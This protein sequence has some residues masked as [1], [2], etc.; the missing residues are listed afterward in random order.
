MV[1]WEWNTKSGNVNVQKVINDS[2]LLANFHVELAEQIDPKYFKFN[3]ISSKNDFSTFKAQR[4]FPIELA[5][6]Q[7]LRNELL[8]SITLYIKLMHIF[9]LAAGI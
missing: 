9:D 8:D 7:Y 3:F 4:I 6:R 5:K 2:Q 1:G